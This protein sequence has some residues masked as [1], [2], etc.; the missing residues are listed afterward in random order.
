MIDSLRIVWPAG[1]QQVVTALKG[2]QQITLKKNAAL[3][4]KT[5]KAVPP[6]FTEV[7]APIKFKQAAYNINDF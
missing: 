1:K 7:G 5:A 4:S 6:L 2:N 3:V